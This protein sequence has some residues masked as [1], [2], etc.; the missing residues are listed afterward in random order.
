MC[1]VGYLGYC[2][3][4]NRSKEYTLWKGLIERCYNPKRRD[5]QMY[6]AKG[7]TV[8]ERW[9]CYAY[10][11][12]DIEKI[13]G[14]NKEKFLN[15]QLDLDKDIKQDGVPIYNKIYSLET[16]IFVDKHINRSTTKRE[17]TPSIGII[18]MRNGYI[19]KTNCP[20]E[21]LAKQIN[22]KTQY[23]TR[24]LRGEA[25]SHNGWTFQYF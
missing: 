21:E 18:S 19:L 7:I 20:V 12:E 1:G 14:Y 6:G 16:C 13:E 9:K 2:D 5:Y 11:L 10:F 8:C 25:K 22:V 4:I 23:I 24:I 3:K 17:P 15:G